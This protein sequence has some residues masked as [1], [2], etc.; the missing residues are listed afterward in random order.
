MYK[1]MTEEELQSSL[2]EA[3]QKAEEMLQMPPVVAP[4]KPIDKV[5]SNDPAL[6]GL[7]TAKFVFT[8]ITF[9]TPN[10]KRF[11][12]VREP[13]GTLREADWDVR[14]RMNQ[15]Y[16]PL[17][18]RQL[19]EPRM[20][21]GEYFKDLLKRK[22]FLF[23]LDRA[24]VQYEPDHP[25]YQKVTAETYDAVNESGEFDMLRSTRHF[26]PFAFYLVRSKKI[27]DLLMDLLESGSIEEANCLLKLYGL[28]HKVEVKVDDLGLVDGVKEFI[29]KYSNKKGQLELALQA[30]IET[31]RRKKEL[32]EGI[33]AA[34][35]N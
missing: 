28:V 17:E 26:G 23:I 20:F 33:R 30:Y 1:F 34:H 14:D 13:D 21:D 15:I 35:G 16:F 32:E 11:I 8:D 5:L 9:G 7:E 2:Q 31:E 3:K 27:D 22:E 10:E 29:K 19:K 25:K 24:C 18:G 6:K 12:V 4:R